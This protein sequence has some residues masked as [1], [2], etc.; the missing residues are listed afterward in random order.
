MKKYLM[1]SMA[2]VALAGTFTSCS[3]E[4]DLLD[5]E[6]AQNQIV[7]N[8]Q[9]A[10]IKTFGQPAANQDWGFGSTLT[11]ASFLPQSHDD[12]WIEL[13]AFEKPEDCT[14]AEINDIWNNTAKL[15]SGKTYYV[16]NDFT[17]KIDFNNFNGDIYLD[18]KITEFSGNPG[19]INLYVL[20]NGSW[21]C[22]ITTGSMI[23]YNRGNLVLPGWALNNQNIKTVYNGGTLLYGGQGDYPNPAAGVSIYSTGDATFEIVGVSTKFESKCDIHGTVHVTGYFDIQTGTTSKYFCG[24]VS[25]DD[26]DIL[27]DSDI[28]TSYI[29]ARNIEL[30]SDNIFL[31]KEGHI[32]ANKI[33]F[34]GDGNTQ[35]GNEYE[36]IKVEANSI[37]LVEANG[38]EFQNGVSTL[39]QHI[40]AGVYVNSDEADNQYD[41]SNPTISGTSKCGGAWGKETETEEGDGDDEDEEDTDTSDWTFVARVFAEDLSAS[42]GSDFDFNDV[43]FDVY[44]TTGQTKIEILAAGGTLPLR[45]AGKEVHEA[46]AEVNSALNITTSTMINT[47]AG[48]EAEV[49]PVIIL[50]YELKTPAAVKTIEIAVEKEIEGIGTNWYE[51]TAETGKP[52]AKFAVENQIEWAAERQPIEE[53]YPDFPKWVRDGTLTNWWE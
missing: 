33:S 53:K 23:I 6:A 5:P 30:R 17:G 3:K 9:Q 41:A 7:L 18:T 45:V 46:F 11:R 39:R 43:V 42:T 10:F 40:G 15:E 24:I 26:N 16:P 27:I 37:A 21:E 48:V 50:N 28:T 25:D 1:M 35:N 22:G 14:T 29:K 4:K 38:F 44:Y 32:V 31:T 8:Y 49:N 19:T 51:V 36:A 20:E 2:A 52:A 12:S 47:G 13:L 34:A